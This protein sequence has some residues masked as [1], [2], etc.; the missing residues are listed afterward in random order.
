[1][2]PKE[3]PD[4]DKMV[5]EFRSEESAFFQQSTSP[6]V[7]KSI[8]TLVNKRYTTYLLPTMIEKIQ[9]YAFH[10][11]M[12][13][14]DVVQRAITEFFMKYEEQEKTPAEPDSQPRLKSYINE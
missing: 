5:N 14:Y 6:Q 4:T 3:K 12:R 7:H 11:K 13:D 2:S 8:S 10:H 9:A 1:M